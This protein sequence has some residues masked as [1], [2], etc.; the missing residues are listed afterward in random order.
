MLESRVRV[1]ES[2]IAEH[3]DVNI[4]ESDILVGGGRGLDREKGFKLIR[5]LT[6]SVNGSVAA[7]RAAV[8]AG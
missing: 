5:E 8:D 3:D 7:S 1:I 2:V 6:A 4:R